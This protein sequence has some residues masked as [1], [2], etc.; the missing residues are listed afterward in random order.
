M[1]S[2]E[3]GT[4]YAFPDELVILVEDVQL[5]NLV[6]LLIEDLYRSLTPD[7]ARHQ[8]EYPLYQA[9]RLELQHICLLSP[10]SQSSPTDNPILTNR[11]TCV[12]VIPVTP[13]EFCELAMLKI[14][15]DPDLAVLSST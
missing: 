11:P 8:L 7:F 5:P 4:P 12:L 15:V 14:L 3:V 9:A 6:D 2:I 1:I 10:L 13:F